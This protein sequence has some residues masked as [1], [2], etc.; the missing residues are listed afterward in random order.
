MSDRFRLTSP[1]IKTIEKHVR[2]QCITLLNL[3]HYWTRRMNVGRFRTVDGRWHTEGK[4][5]DPD[6]V[7]L[8]EF[9]PGFLLEFKRPGGELSPEQQQ[10]HLEIT[11][12][13]Q[14]TIVIVDN[15]EQLE[16]WLDEYEKRI[17]TA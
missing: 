7:V 13:Y 9:Y 11:L 6:Y 14:I 4:P 15:L 12:G 2:D 17:W 8:H 5:G 3:R 1:K 16:R 10:R